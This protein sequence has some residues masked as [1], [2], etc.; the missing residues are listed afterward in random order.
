MRGSWLSGKAGTA[1]DLN[2]V[3]GLE[4]SLPNVQPTGANDQLTS[5]S[6]NG[7]VTGKYD[8]VARFVEKKNN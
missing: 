2:D 6:L 4:L 5:C 8:R 1:D 3:P 7:L